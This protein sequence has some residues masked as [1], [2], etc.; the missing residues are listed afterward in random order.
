MSEE[1]LYEKILKSDQKNKIF[2]EI[3]IFKTEHKNLNPQEHSKR[4]ES[5]ICGI[6]D[7]GHPSDRQKAIDYLASTDAISKEEIINRVKPI[8]DKPIKETKQPKIIEPYSFSPTGRYPTTG[9]LGDYLK[10]ASPITDAPIEFHVATALSVLSIITGRNI[11]MQIGHKKLYP[12]IWLIILAQSGLMRKTTSQNIGKEL[13]K[14]VNRDLIGANEFTREAIVQELADK[15]T[16]I[17]MYSEISSLLTQLEREY[18][19]G[20]KNMLTEI[21]DC[22]DHPYERKLKKE[23]YIINNPYLCILGA[24]TTEWLLGVLKEGDLRSGFLARFL[25]LFA[26][27][28]GGSKPLPPSPVLELKNKLIQN[29]K[30]ISKIKEEMVFSPDARKLYEG[31][32]K[33]IE[34]EIGN[35]AKKDILSSFYVRLIDYCI[36]IAMLYALNDKVTYIEK[37]HFSMALLLIEYFKQNVEYC[38][39]SEFTFTWF[40]KQKKRVSDMIMRKPEIQYSDLLR[41]LRGI[42]ARTLKEILEN[43]KDTDD[44]EELEGRRYICKR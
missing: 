28:K 1:T 40:E 17:L 41:N 32:Y 25:Y 21:Y 42:R 10:Y 15:P 43:L 37:R 24:S 20:L 13:I 4:I 9:F 12:N 30:D 14:N 2:K 6:T 27:K 34:Y 26:H 7:L 8:L 16:L 11:F 39:E 19:R 44:I 23:T 36:K 33:K 3:E 38:I 18:N 35:H 29:L 22:L 5:I 31:W